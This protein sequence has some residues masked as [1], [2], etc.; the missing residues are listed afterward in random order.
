MTNLVKATEDAVK[1]CRRWKGKGKERTLVEELPGV[2]E[3][4][5]QVC[6]GYTRKRYGPDDGV[7]IRVYAVEG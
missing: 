1:T 4:D 2:I 3:E 6:E 5:S 7:E